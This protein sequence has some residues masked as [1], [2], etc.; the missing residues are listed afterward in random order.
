M[1]DELLA[2]TCPACGAPAGEPC[3]EWGTDHV[4]AAGHIERAKL[5]AAPEGVASEIVRAASA[6]DFALEIADA[7]LA[8]AERAGAPTRDVAKLR[9]VV[10]GIR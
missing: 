10:R 9:A 2:V 3:V 1:L 7:A 6:R 8:L 5:A 4:Y